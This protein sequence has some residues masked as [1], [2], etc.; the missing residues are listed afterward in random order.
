MKLDEQKSLRVLV[1]DAIRKAII[2][3]R[4]PPGARLVEDQLAKELGVSRNPVREALHA[5]EGEGLVT[6]SP[7]RGAVVATVTPQ[8]AAQMF[9]V[10]ELLEAFATRMAAR[11]GT[12]RDVT[13]L[14]RLLV[15]T[16]EALETA[17]PVQLGRRN[18]DF[19]SSISLM[20]KNNYL[21]E[22]M[23]SMAR[24]MEWIFRQDAVRRGPGSLDEHAAIVDAIA[25]G[26]E[27]LA[28]SLAAEHVQ[29]ARDHY[30]CISG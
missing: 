5:L 24:R 3:G 20:T 2:T 10:R 22:L 30:L 17:D 6:M 13:A 12:E 8:D 11:N 29:A 1:L 23:R 16:E 28:A 7:R 15:T 19:H 14:R 9:E 4:F 27:D 18:T 25:V 26:N 21:I